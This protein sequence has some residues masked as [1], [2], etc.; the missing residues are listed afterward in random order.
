M[1]PIFFCNKCGHDV[2]GSH[3]CI[4][5]NKIKVS[6]ELKYNYYCKY[7]M[8]IRPINTYIPYDIKYKII[9]YILSYDKDIIKLVHTSCWKTSNHG[10]IYVPQVSKNKIIRTDTFIW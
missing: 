8:A 7:I 6:R 9:Q 5:C 10:V 3:A 2:I 4:I 1:S